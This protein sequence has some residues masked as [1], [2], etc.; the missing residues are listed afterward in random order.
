M[1]TSQRTTGKPTT[2]SEG[3]VRAEA[4]PALFWAWKQQ[5]IWSRTSD[6]LKKQLDLFRAAALLLGILAAVLAVAATQVMGDQPVLGR[7]LGAGTAISA[8]LATL[9]QRG[10]TTDRIRSWTR[11]RS[12]SEALKTE[13]YSYLAGGTR[14]TDSGQ[15]DRILH[16]RSRDLVNKVEGLLGLTVAV[17]PDEKRVPAVTGIEDYITDRVEQQIEGYYRRKA[18]IYMRRVWWLR[19]TASALGAVA[20]ALSAVATWFELPPVSAWVPVATTIGTAVVAHIA[21][22]RYDHLII[23]FQRTAYRLELL[24]QA[25]ACTPGDD[26]TFVDDCEDAI[27]VENQ[28]WMARW[29]DD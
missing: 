6:R 9:V 8:G 11:A 7:S 16:Q 21:A 29:N 26:A 10:V 17:A 3:T 1:G 14:Y 28:G 22:S 15:R 4:S 12:V 23:E 27:S 24:Q 19:A 13:V 5:R 25:R 20:V 2:H 18:A